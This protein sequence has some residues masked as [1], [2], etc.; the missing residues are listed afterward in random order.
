MS[1]SALTSSRAGGPPPVGGDWGDSPY[2]SLITLGPRT[3]KKKP[4][5]MLD[6]DEL[7][8]AHLAIAMGGAEIME[9]MPDPVEA[10]RPRQPAMLLG[11]APMGAEEADEDLSAYP[12]EAAAAD[13]AVEEE[14]DE[15]AEEEADEQVWVPED[16][17]EDGPEEDFAEEFMP[18]AA[19]DEGLPEDEDPAGPEALAPMAPASLAEPALPSIEEQM[20]RMRERL[21]RRAAAVPAPTLTSIPTSIPA[22]IPAIAPEVPAVPAV[23]EA[24]VPTIQRIEIDDWSQRESL[25]GFIP[26]Q[27]RDVAPNAEPDA[28]P[29]ARV[30]AAPEPV[31]LPESSVLPPVAFAPAEPPRTEPTPLEPMAGAPVFDEP[32]GQDEPADLLDLGADLM[33]EE[34]A[35]N[36]WQDPVVPVTRR[37]SPIRERLRDSLAQQEAAAEA[38]PSLLA[39]LWGWLRGRF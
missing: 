23:V 17:P 10:P 31:H 11:L 25:Q 3:F 1:L 5:L 15:P 37:S 20:E 29:P 33:A 34:A 28:E 32:Q 13:V 19:E 18:L 27:E 14:W 22:P 8:K 38:G 2:G 16:E 7:A 6:P 39:R 26:P 21:A 24:R 9:T 35:L 36:A 4:V 30:A 12:A